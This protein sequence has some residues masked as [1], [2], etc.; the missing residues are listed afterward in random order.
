MVAAK[1]S[2]GLSFNV[3]GSSA[4]PSPPLQRHPVAGAAILPHQPHQLLLLA[5]NIRLACWLG[6]CCGRHEKQGKNL[7]ILQQRYSPSFPDAGRNGSRSALPCSKRR[8]QLSSGNIRSDS[9]PPSAGKTTEWLVRFSRLIQRTLSPVL[10]LTRQGKTCSFQ[11]APQL[12]SEPAQ[13]K[14]RAPITTGAL[15]S[16][17]HP[18]F[19]MFP[20][21]QDE[22]LLGSLHITVKHRD[23]WYGRRR[24]D[25]N[26]RRRYPREWQHRT[27]QPC[28]QP[29]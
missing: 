4:G 2:A 25:G 7:P 18:V 26:G 1:P 8:C 10:I 15:F 28:R 21:G 19:I 9:R 11:C 24:R 20:E 3:A 17:D 27:A 22:L 23:R 12:R 6:N 16:R 5:R 29:A 14:K 13:K